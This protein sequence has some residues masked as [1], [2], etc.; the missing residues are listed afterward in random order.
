MHERDDIAVVLSCSRTLL[1]VADANMTALLR[2]A[3]GTSGILALGHEQGFANKTAIRCG[4]L[5][6][7]P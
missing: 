5:R 7:S 3:G 4:P 1:M 6:G 2:S